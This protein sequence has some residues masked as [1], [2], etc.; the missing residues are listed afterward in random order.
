MERFH[1]KWQMENLYMRKGDTM[2]KKLY[3]LM[4][5]AEIEAIVYSEHDHPEKILGPHKVRGGILIQAFL[6]GAKNVFVKHK[7]DGK[8]YQ[9]ELADEAGFFA[10]LLSGKRISSYELIA[11]YEDG[12]EQIG[13]DPYYYADL[14]EEEEWSHKLQEEE[15]PLHERMGAHTVCVVRE[16]AETGILWKEKPG[17]KKGEVLCQG[18]H[19]AFYAPYAMRVSVV[20]DFNHWDGRVNPMVRQ[21]KTALCGVKIS[22]AAS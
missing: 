22:E 2:D 10:L 1:K 13:K 11:R 6:P 7:R 17:R 16:G 20:G 4:D 12:R 8:L 3:D 5:W 19:F 21:G 18:T 14:L 15:I 9:M